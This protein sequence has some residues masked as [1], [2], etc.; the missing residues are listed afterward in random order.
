M[1]TVPKCLFQYARPGQKPETGSNSPILPSI[2]P[3]PAGCQI[4]FALCA[5]F[6]LPDKPSFRRRAAPVQKN[7]IGSEPKKG[8]SIFSHPQDSKRGF[9]Y[10][11]PSFVRQGFLAPPQKNVLAT[12]GNFGYGFE[13]DARS[14]VERGVVPNRTATTCGLPAIVKEPPPSLPSLAR[15][16][17]CPYARPSATS[18]E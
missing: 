6:Y 14:M 10:L 12:A 1:N 17:L 11:T 16:P 13:V 9:F 7:S 15:S 4:V 3:E 5:V 18:G 8:L 2:A